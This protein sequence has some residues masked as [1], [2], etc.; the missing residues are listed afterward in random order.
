MALVWLM[1]A[2]LS[3]D[4]VEA[5]GLRGYFRHPS[6]HD[7][8][9]VFTAEGQQLLACPNMHGG[10]DWEA[11]AYSPLTNTMYMPLRNMCQ[12]LLATTSPDASHRIYALAVRHELAPG[13]DQLGAIHAISAETGKTTWLHEQRAATL[14]LVATGGGL[15]FGGDAHGRFKAMDQVTGE[16]LWE[17]NLGSP[18]SGFPISYEVGGR[19][20]IVASTGPAATTPSFNNLTPEAQPSNGNNIFVFALPE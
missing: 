6:V 12:R 9:V 2:G 18:V 13:T 19:Q 20:Y 4:S 15:I 3:A 14:S 7:Q 5:A 11:G 10:K 17:I 16:V 1:V 8:T